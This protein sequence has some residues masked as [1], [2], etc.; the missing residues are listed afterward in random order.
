SLDENGAAA[1]RYTECQLARLSNQ[2]LIEIDQDT[3]PFRPN[4]D[5]TKSEPMMLPARIPNLLINGTTEIAV[6]IA[7]NIPPHNL[8]EICTALIKLLD[9]DEL[10]SVQ[11]CRWVKGPNFPTGDQILNSADELKEIYKT[12]AGAVR[13]RATWMP[14]TAGRA[15]K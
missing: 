12:S 2:L 6:G 9:N 13:L 8:D 10:T 14:G 15:S 5:G 11:L 3:V 1:M 4:Y 7:T